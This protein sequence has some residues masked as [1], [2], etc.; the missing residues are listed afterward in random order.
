MSADTP[1]PKSR[2]PKATAPDGAVEPE[3]V[4][5]EDPTPA[6]VPVVVTPASDTAAVDAAGSA[7]G[8]VASDATAASAPASSVAGAQG[9]QVVFVQ[10]PAPPKVRS[11]RVVGVLLALLGAVVFAVVLAAVVALLLTLNV[12]SAFVQVS[13]SSFLGSAAFWIPV[14]VFT[15][16]FILLVLIVNRGGWAAHVFGSLLVALAV[17]FGT[18]G[19]ILVSSGLFPNESKGLTFASVAAQPTVIVA[20]LVAREVAVWIGLAI[21]ARGRRVKTRNV[22]ARTAWEQEQADKKAEIERAATPA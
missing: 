11:N 16:A 5:V 1:T 7:T 12:S 13:I 15:L 20:A 18:I 8:E 3:T 22:E 2:K 14:L 9:Q 6:D 21:A 17:Y 10:T 4:V 19:L